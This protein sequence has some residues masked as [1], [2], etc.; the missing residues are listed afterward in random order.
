[1]ILLTTVVLLTA[2]N[3]LLFESTIIKGHSDVISSLNDGAVL[4]ANM[5]LEQFELWNFEV[6]VEKRGAARGKP[7]FASPAPAIKCIN[8]T[9]A[10]A[11]ANIC[12]KNGEKTESSILILFL[13]TLAQRSTSGREEAT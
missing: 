7:S 8:A 1:M 5:K 2:P 3:P 13:Y 10:A 6:V 12:R 11:V 4:V 9:C